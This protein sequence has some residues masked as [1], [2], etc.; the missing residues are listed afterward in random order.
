MWRDLAND[1]K[2]IPF[3]V[4]DSAKIWRVQ[5]ATNRRGHFAAVPG[6]DGE[7]LEVPIC[8]TH[9]ELIG[10]LEEV[11]DDCRNRYRVVALDGKKQVVDTLGVVDL[12]G[13]HDASDG[14]DGAGPRNAAPPNH[15]ADSTNRSLTETLGEQ[16]KL[17]R[18]LVEQNKQRDGET[19]KTLRQ[20]H[21]DL[22]SALSAVSQT[23]AGRHTPMP[24]VGALEYGEEEEDEAEEPKPQASTAEKMQQVI[25]MMPQLMQMFEFF[26]GMTAGGDGG[27]TSQVVETSPANGANGAAS[28]FSVGD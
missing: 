14:G 20:A 6:T 5:R 27:G 2:G 8:T 17:I 3:D 13:N 15:V 9:K 10:Y 28:P 16:N 22:T 18:D 23:L 7:P 19:L 21:S 11:G 1:E 24:A 12:R 4:P 25:A 26:K